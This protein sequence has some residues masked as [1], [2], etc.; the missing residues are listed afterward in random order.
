[1][2]DI[3]KCGHDA[4][5]AAVLRAGSP[6]VF[7]EMLRQFGDVL[8][9]TI[10]VRHIRKSEPDVKVVWAIMEPYV[11]S[12]EPFVESSLGP[13]EIV[14]LPVTKPHPLDCPYRIS[15]VRR[16]AL[17]KGVKRAFGCGVGTWGWKSGSI[18]DAVF[19]NAGIRE[20][21]VERR[22]WLPVDDDDRLFGDEFVET[23]H[24]G[25]GF[26]TLELAGYSIEIP[27]LTSLW[28]E[29]LI[30]D[31]RL[32][33]VVLGLSRDGPLPSGAI[34]G[35]DITLRKSKVLIQRSS[36]FV[37]RGSGL[38]VLA[39]TNGCEQPVVEVVGRE[40]SMVGI[41][42]RRADDRHVHAFPTINLVTKHVN[43]LSG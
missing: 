4:I 32:P 27:Q 14:P 11:E 30:H 17:L 34:D 19:D 37:G 13:H 7:V 26:V 39:A 10:V 18:V 40:I 9:S 6:V 22:P 1:M 31:I 3:E 33:V 20:L 12:F 24:L 38:S 29:Q 21:S 35:R 8:H 36:C 23:H 5:E 16:A 25:D 43:S 2:D 42:Y 28:F 15:W 41:G